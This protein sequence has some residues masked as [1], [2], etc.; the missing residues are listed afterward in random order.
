[1]NVIIVKD[2]EEMSAM[3]AEITIGALK[4]K[5]N[6]VLGLATGSTPVGL[7]KK[8]AEAHQK[9]GL[10]FSQ[11]V[12]FNLD[13][14]VGLPADHPQSYR[15]FM[16][17]NLFDHINVQPRNIHIPDGMAEPLNAH[18]A[19]YEK[20]IADAGGVDLQVLG[21]GRDGHIGFNEPGT[22]LA[23]DTHVT[24]LTRETIEDN[25]RFF[26]SEADVPRFAITMGISTILHSASALFMVS[27][28]NKADTVRAAIEGP[29][30]SMVTASALQMHPNCTAIIDEAA[31]S[32]L[33]LVDFYRFQQESWGLIADK[34]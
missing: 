5:P 10:D 4:N 25:A 13:E 2:Y 31:A 11:V 27:G 26:E 29:V 33:E 34:L 19:D 14:Y 30:T 1:M 22:S 18:C 32:K 28:E 3:A 6:L 9:D 21:V 23:S 12:T 20:M 8:L 16:D 15:R 7:Y 24:A 17:E